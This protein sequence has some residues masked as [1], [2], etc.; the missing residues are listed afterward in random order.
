[1]TEPRA[2]PVTCIVLHRPQFGGSSKRIRNPL[3]GTL[4]IG[5]EGNAHMTI[6]E[7]RVVRPV[8]SF[9]LV[10]RLRDKESS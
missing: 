6:V 5:R 10:E 7:D 9:D 4:V 3:G 8:G 1:M 2:K